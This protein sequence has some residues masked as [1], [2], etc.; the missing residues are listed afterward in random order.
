MIKASGWTSGTWSNAS[1]GLAGLARERSSGNGRP[2][3][4]PRCRRRPTR[5][6]RGRS[7][8]PARVDRRTSGA[9]AVSVARAPHRTL[10][11]VPAPPGGRRGASSPR[12]TLRGRVFF[13]IL[14]RGVPSAPH[15]QFLLQVRV[16]GNDI[17]GMQALR[18]SIP[19]EGALGR[20]ISRHQPV[21]TRPCGRD[22]AEIGRRLSR[23]GP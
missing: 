23:E 14:V 10:K 5:G 20:P 4:R 13:S 1:G 17:E 9:E 3:G 11:I 21:T 2:R 16:T 22:S 12:R 6:S 19:P 8:R 18:R 7:S 15:R